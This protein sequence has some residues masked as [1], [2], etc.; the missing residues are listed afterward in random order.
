MQP[1]TVIYLKPGTSTL[2]INFADS[3]GGPEEAQQRESFDMSLKKI[4]WTE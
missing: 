3:L 1:L 4:T 2:H